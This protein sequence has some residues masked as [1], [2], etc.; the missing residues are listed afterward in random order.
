MR[1]RLCQA[2]L[3]LCPGECCSLV[4]WSEYTALTVVVIRSYAILSTVLVLQP[5]FSWMFAKR[6]HGAYLCIC[7]DSSP[8]PSTL[9]F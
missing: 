5:V 9:D 8:G 7:V 1:V 4:C 3:V 6:L 2:R